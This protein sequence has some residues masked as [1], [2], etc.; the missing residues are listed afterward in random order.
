MLRHQGPRLRMALSE[1]HPTRQLPPNLGH[2]PRCSQCPA[3]LLLAPWHLGSALPRAYC[4]NSSA[5]PFSTL[6]L[7]SP[8]VAAQPRPY[9][10]PDRADLRLLFGAG[11]LQRCQN[12][13]WTFR[14]FLNQHLLHIRM[15]PTSLR[16]DKESLRGPTALRRIKE[17]TLWSAWHNGQLLRLAHKASGQE[18][19]CG[20]TQIGRTY[21]ETLR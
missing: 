18:S 5:L 10:L 4:L 19:F 14:L 11:G 15:R 7:P 1:R 12:S 16:F 3:I 8:R 2:N 20:Q 13:R 17:T 21:F 6:S 9:P